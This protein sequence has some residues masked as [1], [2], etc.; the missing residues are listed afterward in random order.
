MNHLLFS[1][2]ALQPT[3][4]VRPTP[5]PAP[6]FRITAA[7]RHQAA[8]PWPLGLAQQGGLALLAFTGWALRP[9]L[10]SFQQLLSCPLPPDSTLVHWL[11]H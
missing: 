5:G 9:A 1:D 6:R 8:Q 10:A 7:A 3:R 11:V 4:W 2:A